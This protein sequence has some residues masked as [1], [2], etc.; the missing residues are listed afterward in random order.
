MH[1]F[2]LN[3]TVDLDAEVEELTSIITQSLDL[4]IKLPENVLTDLRG[5]FAE[6]TA[7]VFEYCINNTSASRTGE[8]SIVLHL[9]D[10]LHKIMP[11]LR[12]AHA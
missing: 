3:I 2:K 4:G 11:A 6:G 1:D 7:G 9:T 5:A 8:Y 10:K 12:A